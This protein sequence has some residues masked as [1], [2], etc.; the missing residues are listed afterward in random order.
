MGNAKKLVSKFLILEGRNMNNLII[1]YQS[2][3][4][5]TE[6]YAN[7]LSETL[8]CEMVRLKDTTGQKLSEYDTIIFGSRIHAGRIDELDKARK[9]YTASGASRLVLFVTGGTPAEAEVVI[10]K[11]WRDNLTA[12]ELSHIPHFYMPGGLC[13]EKM[14]LPDRLLMK[15]AAKMMSK[16]KNKSDVEAGF[17]QAISA[18]YDNSDIKYTHPLVEKLTILLYNSA[19]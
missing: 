7:W 12:E 17:A 11:M 8:D 6:K 16:E 2:S 1:V 3:T 19:E 10:D 13:Y 18:S 5:F 15:M 9:L 4:G 14:S